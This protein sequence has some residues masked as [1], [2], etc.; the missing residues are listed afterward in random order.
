MRGCQSTSRRNA[1]T[2]SRISTV[3]EFRSSASES[4]G[5]FTNSSNVL[6]GGHRKRPGRSAGST[7]RASIAKVRGTGGS[8]LW[9]TCGAGGIA[10]ALTQPRLL[11]R[12]R[13]SQ[14]MSERAPMSETRVRQ[15]CSQ[16]TCHP[17]SRMLGRPAT[18]TF[19]VVRAVL[20]CQCA[21]ELVEV[22]RQGIERQLVLERLRRSSLVDTHER[23]ALG[24]ACACRRC[25]GA[26]QGRTSTMGTAHDGTGGA[27]TTT[28]FVAT[29][30]QHFSRLA[31][32]TSEAPSE[33]Y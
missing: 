27:R 18:H 21:A 24:C 20:I 11:L 28:R 10:A 33:E 30:F 29:V 2:A 22:R 12:S 25:V 5:A 14:R 13:M 4:L 7:G 6:R 15:T 23:V 8:L 17:G 1:F 16:H 32:S 19:L 3:S 31:A 9:Y 26:V